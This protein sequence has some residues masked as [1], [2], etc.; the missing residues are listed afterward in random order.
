MNDLPLTS[1]ASTG[2]VFL[3]WH[4]LT[5]VLC[6]TGLLIERGL[7]RGNSHVR[8]LLL[9]ATLVLALAVPVTC[10]VWTRLPAISTKPMASSQ[11]ASEP[12]SIPQS[13]LSVID[14]DHVAVWRP[15]IADLGQYQDRL[16][17]TTRSSLLL[18]QI[19]YVFFLG[20]SFFS[21]LAL[22]IRLF[23]SL[24]RCGTLRSRGKPADGLKEG[25]CR[26]LA[27]MMKVVAPPVFQVNGLEG[28]LL[29]G[30]FNPAI[31][32]PDGVQARNEIYGHEL[33]HLKRH[34]MWWHLFARLTTILMPL[35]PGFWLLKSALEQAD[36]DV[37]DDMVLV[38]GANRSAYAE[39]LLNVAESQHT[40]SA[41]LCLPMAAFRS[42]L[43]RRLHRLMD[44]ARPLADRI[45][46]SSLSLC[47][48]PLLVVGILAGAIYL[49]AERPLQAA[50]EKP[51]HSLT[52]EEAKNQGIA[53]VVNRHTILWVAVEQQGAETEKL[54]KANY[55]GD[56]LN[57]RVADM[58]QNVL[59]A[60]IDRQ[61]IID[62]FKSQGG[63]IPEK[64]TNERIDDI[65]KVQ[66]GGDQAA[67]LKT[68]A[69]RH[70]TVEKYREE[71][72]DNAI[73]GYMKN[74][75]VSN[76]LLNYYQDHLDLF[77][78]D[79]QINV[80]MITIWGDNKH[81]LSDHNQNP[82][83]ILAEQVLDQVRKGADFLALV[84]KYNQD[85]E[86][87]PTRWVTSDGPSWVH[88]SATA[89]AT[90]EKL[91]PG[92]TSD[93]IEGSEGYIIARVNERRL[94]RIGST[95]ATTTQKEALLNIESKKIGEAWLAH[96]RA[97]AQVQTFE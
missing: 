77:P 16:V 8:S 2:P 48:G 11:V 19:S 72:E 57:R 40:A 62:D 73:V 76:K 54:L 44:T 50:D 29:L 79:E 91:Q 18:I 12:A 35:Q 3:L 92:Q 84:K 63:F 21:S 94:A 53:A 22:L 89:W 42:K 87:D 43:E 13:S 86:Q 1:I 97:N 28:P 56:D 5:L 58:R 30:F 80:T 33:T 15:L 6:V 52:T 34:D 51:D 68:L 69:E 61:L 70:T 90:I 14:W 74:K 41:D 10:F 32:I 55:S 49:D 4:F 37:C 27:A 36:E 20:M 85:S 67:F 95:A 7:R 81:A 59:K 45:S 65:V 24:V 39:L 23:I 64:Y 66:Y 71:I 60:L 25:K 78:Q 83:Y 88:G 93:I 31:L 26:A 9:R 75:N 82:K 46:Y 17:T 38:Q 47:L 96:L